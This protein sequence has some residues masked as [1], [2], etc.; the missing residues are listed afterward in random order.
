M[1]DVE[2]K[3]DWHDIQFGQFGFFG[4]GIN[5]VVPGMTH[6][7]RYQNLGDE[8]RIELPMNRYEDNDFLGF[9]LCSIYVPLGN[10]CWYAPIVSYGLGCHLSLYGDQFGFGDYI[11][12]YSF[13]NAILVVNQGIKCG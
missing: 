11:S 13:V 1:E 6:W 3:G 7:I 5:F 12:F 8:I 9:A 10:T 4:K 2:S